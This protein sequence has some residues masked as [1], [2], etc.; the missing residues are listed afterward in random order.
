MRIS[1]MTDQRDPNPYS[2]DTPVGDELGHVTRFSGWHLPPD[3][4]NARSIEI[5][6]DGVPTAG[7]VGSSRADL[8]APFPAFPRALNCGF[9]GDLV[10]PKRIHEGQR[11]RTRIDVVYAPGR[12]AS[13]LEREFR[14][15][16]PWKPPDLRARA[17]SCGEILQEPVTGAG[18]RFNADL[19]EAFAGSKALPVVDGVPHFHPVPK[20]PCVRLL[21]PRSTHPYGALAK[22]LID[23][24]N[25]L[26]LD[27]GSGIQA[28][29]RLRPHVVN[30]DAIHFPYVDVVNTY[31]DLPFR[32][33]TFD[34]VVSQAVFEHLP[35]PAR[36]VGE[37]YRVLKPG[38][39]V[40]I[41]TGFLVPLHGDPDHYFNMTGSALR[42]IMRDFEIG[43]IGVQ[44]YQN[45]SQGL[46]M[47]FE[48]ALMS[49]RPGIWRQRVE[50]WLQETRSDAAAL[51]DDLGIIGREVLAAGYYVIARRPR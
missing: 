19:S 24:A 7:T 35:D 8:V 4:P 34:C 26:V 10:L 11:I 9:F 49:L 17:F 41:D 1:R 50:R 43:E 29:D 40:L 36:S 5:C 31:P 46:I 25:G 32:D 13:L 48:H 37:I 30:L 23:E 14:V 16:A 38:G 2:L 15:S 45:P 27:F 42:R 47:Q 20:L 39:R 51:D 22:Q 33:A 6:I 44:P 3:N 18:V 28:P 21:E 12:R